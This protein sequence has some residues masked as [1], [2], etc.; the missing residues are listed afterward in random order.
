MSKFLD[1]YFFPPEKGNVFDASRY[2]GDLETGIFRD[3]F[4]LGVIESEGGK[5]HLKDFVQEPNALYVGAM[6]SGKS[7]AAAFTTTTWMAANSDQTIMFICDVL[8]G[9]ADYAPLFSLPNVYTSVNE[10]GFDAEEGT[11][12]VIDLVY[13]EAMA[14]QELFNEVSAPNITAYEN[15]TG[16][17]MARI[18]VVIEEFH[19]VPNKVF[20][21]DKNYKKK[22]TI[23]EKFFTLM[24]VGRAQGVW[25]VAA[26]QR[27]LKSDVPS[28][29]VSNF[30]NKQMFKVS[31]G[32]A[33]YVL[34][35]ARPSLLKSSQKGRCYSD[36]GAIQ[37]PAFGANPKTDFHITMKAVL[38]RYARPLQAECAYLNDKLIKNYLNGKDTK[39]LYKNKKL[40]E[41]AET[42]ESLHGELVIET[43][44]EKLGHQWMSVDSKLDQYGICGI[45]TNEL[46]QRFVIMY[47]PGGKVTGKTLVNLARSAKA[48]NAIS[49]I[50]Y[51]PMVGFASTV[52]RD[53]KDEKLL[54]FDHTDMIRIA[55]QIDAGKVDLALR[56]YEELANNDDDEM[57]EG[58][59]S[60]PRT[61]ARPVTVIDPVKDLNPTKQYVKPDN[62]VEYE[63]A[64]VDTSKRSLAKKTA[65]EIEKDMKRL[66]GLK[67]ARSVRS[68]LQP[69][70]EEI[71]AGPPLE[72]L[73]KYRTKHVS[74]ERVDSELKG[75]KDDDF[76]KR[77]PSGK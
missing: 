14:R 73:E 3:R 10:K 75:T 45:A 43:L 63:A 59:A 27:S 5:W 55:R 40:S 39:D 1:Q 18:V 35:D 20:E 65:S 29:I 32:E 22:H 47:I 51:S 23:A 9:A 50:L 62:K 17:K 36:F 12:R 71:L 30:L 57:F 42:I 49:G 64:Q 67:V 15:K 74:A 66:E 16:K 31:L 68:I 72:V 34:G 6:G 70:P 44:H 8:K 25:F 2:L 19:A 4:C 69:S 28:E 33:T 56:M 76:L 38:E 26:S 24:K 41:L 58:E 77:R 61:P 53:A 21:F 46:N 7:Y 52:Y 37:F 13:S 48:N 11:R 60:S 54:I